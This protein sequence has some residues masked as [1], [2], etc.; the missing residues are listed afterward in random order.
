[1]FS[2]EWGKAVPGHSCGVSGQVFLENG[3]CFCSVHTWGFSSCAC[4]TLQ[5]FHGYKSLSEEEA[6]K[7]FKFLCVEEPPSVWLP[8]EMYF[9]LTPSQVFTHISLVSHPNVRKV[10]SFINKAHGGRLLSLF[11]YSEQMDFKS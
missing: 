3:D 10:D 6:D 7:F 8:K 4:Y 1:M 5:T 11:R 9:L 2:V